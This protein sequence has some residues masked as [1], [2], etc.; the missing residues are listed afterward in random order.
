MDEFE[1]YGHKITYDW[2]A[3]FKEHSLQA[4]ND[5]KAIQD[6]DV[7]IIYF[8]NNQ[9]VYRGVYCELGGAL[10]LNKPVVIIGNAGN[11]C[12]FSEHPLVIKMSKTASPTEIIKAID[13]QGTSD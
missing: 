9:V 1:K 10:A 5:L 4:A 12:I 2:T 6:A 13:C 8:I 7:I 11:D 3:P